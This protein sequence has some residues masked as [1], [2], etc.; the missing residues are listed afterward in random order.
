MRG[1]AASAS[2]HFYQCVPES[3]QADPSI[4]TE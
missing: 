4:S 1:L 3:E 2:D